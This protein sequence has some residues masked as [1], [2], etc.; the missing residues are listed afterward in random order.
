MSCSLFGMLWV[1]TL[2]ISQIIDRSYL[3]FNVDLTFFAPGLILFIISLGVFR[4]KRWAIF[5]ASLV[6]VLCVIFY[7]FQL[8]CKYS[9]PPTQPFIHLMFILVSGLY[10]FYAFLWLN[11]NK[12]SYESKTKGAIK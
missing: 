10:A 8:F 12:V 11:T 6:G 1:I 9:D 4:A 5:L 7:G 3:I 2:V